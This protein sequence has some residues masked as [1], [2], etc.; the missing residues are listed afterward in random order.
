MVSMLGCSLNGGHMEGVSL[1]LIITT[2]GAGLS[3][4][5]AS[6][7]HESQRLSAPGFQSE[8]AP[9]LAAGSDR[10]TPLQAAGASLVTTSA[11]TPA[12][13]NFGPTPI[14]TLQQVT[15]VIANIGD[16]DSGPVEL[17]S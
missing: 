1:P 5:F 3:I 2:A 13:F 9:N 11:E 7:G 14:Q 12:V 6:S 15:W 17:S 10:P 4:G 8:A 16:A